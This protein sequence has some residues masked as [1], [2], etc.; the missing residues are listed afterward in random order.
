[1]LDR[2]DT[3]MPVGQLAGIGFRIGDELLQ[4]L[5]RHRR[6]HGDAEK[7]GG[8]A[9]NRIQVLDR[10]IERPALEQRLVDVRLRPAEQDRV[11][12]GP[13]AGDGGGTERGAAA[14]DV[15]DH[16]GAE[17]RLDPVRPWA[18]DGVERTARR[19]R[20]HEPDR[21]RRIGLRPRD[22]RE[23]R[24][25]GGTRRQMQKSSTG[26]RHEASLQIRRKE[27]HTARKSARVLINRDR[28]TIATDVR[29]SPKSGTRA[30]IAALRIRATS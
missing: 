24:Q 9:R 7:I 10:I 6:M 14:A 16:H 27:D 15:L 22:A 5:N 23:C 13:G 3:G 18:T 25:R 28:S 12:V 8:H 2:A 21:P 20:N 4:A 30:D 29:L 19:K 11:A 17:Q 1:M 26:K